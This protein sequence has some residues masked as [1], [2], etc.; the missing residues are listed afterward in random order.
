MGAT[1]A[2]LIIILTAVVIICTA[3]NIKILKN[4]ARLKQEVSA[5]PSQGTSTVSQESRESNTQLYEEV[6][7][8]QASTNVNIDINENKAYST[9]TDL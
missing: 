1:L 2:G 6:D 3:V 9:I 8:Y 7:L 5:R 4:K